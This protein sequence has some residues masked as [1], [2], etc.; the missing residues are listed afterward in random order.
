MMHY[1]VQVIVA[2]TAL[3][4]YTVAKFEQTAIFLLSA[5]DKTD[6]MAYHHVILIRPTMQ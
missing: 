6:K 1:L 3:K 4:L 2:I 5:I